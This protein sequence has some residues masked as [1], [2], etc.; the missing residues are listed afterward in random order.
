MRFVNKCDFTHCQ[1]GEKDTSKKKEETQTDEPLPEGIR[2]ILTWHSVDSET[3]TE[4]VGPG[5][6]FVYRLAQRINRT[7]RDSN[8]SE[9]AEQQ[10]ACELDQ[11]RFATDVDSQLVLYTKGLYLVLLNPV[12][13]ERLR[14]FRLQP[15]VS[16]SEFFN[17]CYLNVIHSLV[18]SY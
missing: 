7:Q 17:F 5:L 16:Y 10:D 3:A 1:K 13:L 15:W 8:V 18:F 4:L 12:T 11:E 2:S 9:D 6:D 14:Q